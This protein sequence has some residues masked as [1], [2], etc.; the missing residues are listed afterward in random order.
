MTDRRRVLL[1]MLIQDRATGHRRWGEFRNK[2]RVDERLFRSD[3]IF[4]TVLVFIAGGFLFLQG[5]TGA[6]ALK[7]AAGDEPPALADAL[8]LRSRWTLRASTS[9]WVM[10]RATSW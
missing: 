5:I 6:G 2:G 10:A 9:R 8:S 4:I 1:G 3:L 7:F